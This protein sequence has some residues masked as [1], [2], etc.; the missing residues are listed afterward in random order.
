MKDTLYGELSVIG[1]RGCEDFTNQVDFYLKEWRRHDNDG[2]FVIDASCPTPPLHTSA[3]T[4]ITQTIN[5]MRDFFMI[6]NLLDGYYIK[7][8]GQKIAG[9]KKVLKVFISSK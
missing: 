6:D 8:I 1:M 7:D 2:T 5:A 4:A 9:W 3:R